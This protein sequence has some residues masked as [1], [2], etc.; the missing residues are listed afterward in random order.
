M[1]FNSTD[2]GGAVAGVGGTF[3]VTLLGGNF[4]GFCVL[5]GYEK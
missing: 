3:A 4:V 5:K 1:G 2:A